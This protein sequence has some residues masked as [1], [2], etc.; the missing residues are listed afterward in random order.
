MKLKTLKD[1]NNHLNF[2]PV[3]DEVMT[4]VAG[5]YHPIGGEW[6]DK[7]FIY[8]DDLRVVAREWIKALNDNKI[9]FGGLYS[10]KFNKQ[11]L[12]MIRKKCQEAMV[13]WIEK[14]FNLE[15]VIE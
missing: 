15:K 3:F 13:K 14:F 2:F 9:I 5:N 1:I 10:N 7:Q 11:D 6:E 8:L 12:E 4:D